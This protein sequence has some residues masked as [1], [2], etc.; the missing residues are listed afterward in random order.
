MTS[1]FLERPASEWIASNDLAFAIRD[2]YPASPGHTLVVPRRLTP[3][4]FDATAEER[5]AIFELV[6]E[7]KRQ[8]DATDHPPDGYNIGINCGTA[9]ASARMAT[10]K[11]GH[12]S[13]PEKVAWG[14]NPGIGIEARPDKAVSLSSLVEG[15]EGPCT[16]TVRIDFFPSGSSSGASLD[17]RPWQGLSS[18]APSSAE[19]WATCSSKDKA[20]STGS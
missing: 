2:A 13:L 15:G 16:S 1:P 8:L 10:G 5:R 20:G 4:W 14:H 18:W 3:T 17:T 12:A 11:P 19:C 6:D 7:V 9:S